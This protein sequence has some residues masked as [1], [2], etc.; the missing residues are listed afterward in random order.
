[1]SSNF[2]QASTNQEVNGRQMDLDQTLCGVT[3]SLVSRLHC[4][5]TLNLGTTLPLRSPLRVKLLITSPPFHGLSIPPGVIVDSRCVCFDARGWPGALPDRGNQQALSLMDEEFRTVNTQ[6]SHSI[7]RRRVFKEPCFCYESG[8]WHTGW[9][10][11][12]SQ[13][14]GS[15]NTPLSQRPDDKT[16]SVP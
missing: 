13:T 7:G 10:R 5:P 15:V 1:M 9:V 3:E 8:A 11:P 2:R 12:H 14:H 6:I 16:I 4:I